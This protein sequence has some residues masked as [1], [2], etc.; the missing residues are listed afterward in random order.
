MQPSAGRTASADRYCADRTSR[1]QRYLERDSS[2][3][4]TDLL[5]EIDADPT[6]I[7]WG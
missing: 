3:F 2:Q 1:F 4:V 6:G 5:E 7:F